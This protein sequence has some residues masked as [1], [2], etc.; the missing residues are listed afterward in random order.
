MLKRLVMWTGYVSWCVLAVT[1]VRAEDSQ[2]AKAGET[3]PVQAESQKQIPADEKQAEPSVKDA[4]KP[5]AA[6]PAKPAP[7]V[8]KIGDL[9]WHTDYSAAYLQAVAEHK[10]M[11]MFFR[12]DKDL[13][14][15]GQLEQNVLS[16]PE[17]RDPLSKFVRVVLFTSATAPLAKDAKPG[18]KPMRLLDYPCY[19]HMHGQA[20]LAIVDLQTKGDPLFGHCISAHPFSSNT[21]GSVGTVKIMLELPRGTITQRT[22]TYVLRT[23]PEQPASVWGQGHPVLFDQCRHA[24]QLMV[25]YGSVGHHDWGTRSAY[26]GGQLGSSPMEVASMGSGNNLFEVA[27]SAVNLW[28]GSGVHWGMMITPCRHFGYDMV[29]SPNGTWYANGLIAP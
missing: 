14:T 8:R 27:H 13:L 4:D 9:P 28:R 11:L 3:Q 29:Q 5:T 6:P 25:N 18:T 19:A 26:V 16:R 12:S 24:S 10:Q 20:G 21:L 2:P 17:L 7:E 23:H 15:A 22:L 1:S